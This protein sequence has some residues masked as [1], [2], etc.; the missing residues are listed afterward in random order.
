MG[1]L[2]TVN[3]RTSMKLSGHYNL[4][5]FGIGLADCMKSP[6]ATE[7][8]PSRSVHRPKSTVDFL[9]VALPRSRARIYLSI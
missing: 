4:D 6:S 2:P 3:K 9:N 1:L 8:A 7:Q 5:D